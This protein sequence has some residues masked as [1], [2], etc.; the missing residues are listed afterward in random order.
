VAILLVACVACSDSSGPN[1]YLVVGAISGYDTDD[2]QFEIPDTVTAGVPFTATVHTY[3]DGCNRVGPTEVE[4][5][6][7]GL[8]ITPYDHAGVGTGN[9]PTYLQVMAH[10]VSLVFS[11]PGPATVRVRGVDIADEPVEFSRSTWV[12]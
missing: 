3:G 1:E 11:T 5:D 4:T 8:V 6:S 2:P 9:C 10:E 7:L 12:R